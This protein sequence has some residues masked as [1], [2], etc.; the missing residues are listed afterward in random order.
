MWKLLNGVIR[1]FRPE[2]SA[3]CFSFPL[4]MLRMPALV[5]QP[6][7]AVTVLTVQGIGQ[8]NSRNSCF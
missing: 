7:A 5:I 4:G 3:Q 1:Y 2:D 6:L 8:N